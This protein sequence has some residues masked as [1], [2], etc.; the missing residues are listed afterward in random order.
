MIS[1]EQVRATAP[2]GLAIA[3]AG[4]DDP[5]V[6]Y[7][8]AMAA[9]EGIIASG[10]LCMAHVAG[11]AAAARVAGAGLDPS[12]FRVDAAAGD[13]AACR[14]AVEAVRAGGADILMKGFVQTADFMRAVLSKETGI[15]SG[16]VLSQVGVYEIPSLGRLIAMADVGIVISPDLAQLAG[17]AAGAVHVAAALGL[18]QADAD[19]GDGDGDGD[20]ACRPRVAMLSSVETV[21]PAIPGNA[22]AA[23]VVQ[24]AARGQIPGAG[25][26]AGPAG[27]LFDGP[28]A[29][30]NAISP[31]AAA[32]KGIVSEVAG[33]ADVLIAPDLN[34]GNML[35]KSV[36]YFAG[37]G[38]AGV[39]T[40]AR[41]PV[42]LTS[43]ADTPETKLNSI[44]VAA[45]LGAVGRQNRWA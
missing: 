32:H 37:A 30:D 11:E 10:T 42:V 14:A 43:R 31:A 19:S 39:V 44:A 36:I 29:L 15:A 20:G 6:L 41:C 35:A 24:M 8:V 28:L 4:A 17:I 34:S 18:G 12:A 45:I 21:N 3:V 2:R 7:A 27:A 40:G 9:A 38:A 33:R 26:K 23:L 25:P 16:G 13:A 22:N 1:F 5:E